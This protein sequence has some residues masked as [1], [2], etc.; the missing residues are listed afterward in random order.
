VA[1]TVVLPEHA[2]LAKVEATRSY[3]AK[4][5]LHGA[6]FGEATQKARE[7]AER[8][9]PVFVSAF[10]D[11]QIVTGQ[12]TVGL[13]IAEECPQA[14]LVLVPVGGGGLIAGIG[15][16]LKT[17]YPGVRLIGVQ[18]A[19]SPGV[20]RS[21]ESGSLTQLT[22]R[23]TLADGV[24]V[25][26]PGKVTLPL[27]QRYVDEIVA[28]DEEAIAQAVVLLLE[29]TKLVAEGAGALAVAAL[30]S[31]A[32]KTEGRRTVAVISGGNIDINVLASVVQHGLLHASRYLT[33]VID[34]DD[35]PG[36][37]AA[38]LTLVASTGANVLE[39][40]HERQGIHL[41]LRG[42]E[43]RLLLE[44]RDTA[45]IEE[46]TAALTG[47]GYVLTQSTAT[48]RSFRPQAWG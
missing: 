46:V 7:M 47:A 44:T 24:A 20:L 45:H 41:P 26:G 9:G 40:N 1:A 18:A 21:W 28:V 6:N 38:L 42:V 48:S 8:E 11:E 36:S 15:V 33:L 2:A 34:L 37:L 4:V 10:D 27:I 29:R 16:V 14:E 13:E 25:P 32:V 31:G 3:G 35:Q 22:P 23:P 43:V 39:V 30:L 12:G 5:L 17:L 19:A